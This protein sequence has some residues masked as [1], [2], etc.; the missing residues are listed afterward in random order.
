MIELGQVWKCRRSAGTT[1]NRYYTVDFKTE[2]RTPAATFDA[3]EK[4]SEIKASA[5][6]GSARTFIDESRE[7]KNSGGIMC[8]NRC[9]EYEKYSENN[10]NNNVVENYFSSF[11]RN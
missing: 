6:L 3:R 7:K 4:P 11:Q 8:S 10:A 1:R 9:F 5:Y 2:V